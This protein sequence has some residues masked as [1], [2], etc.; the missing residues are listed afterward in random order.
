MN[1]STPMQVRSLLARGQTRDYLE[2]LHFHGFTVTIHSPRTS[3]NGLYSVTA[4]GDHGDPP[5]MLRASGVHLDAAIREA[6]AQLGR[7]KLR[8]FARHL[9]AEQ[10]GAAL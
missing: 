7:P 6:A 4:Y 10:L 5:R 8:A 9:L 1:T 2:A 3:A